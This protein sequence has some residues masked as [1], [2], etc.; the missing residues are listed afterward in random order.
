MRRSWMVLGT[1]LAFAACGGDSSTNPDTGGDGDNSGD[2]RVVK[3]DPSFQS[4]IQE[5]FDRRG[6]AASSCHGSAEAAGLRL[7]SGNSHA[8]LV[9]VPATSEAG[10][11]V[12]T[13]DAQNSYLV[14]KIEGRQ[15]AGGRMPVGGSP[16]DTIDVKNIRNWIDQGAKN[17]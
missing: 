8:E 6:C 11:R 1:A 7:T 14:I 5:I 10:T 2:N 9:G 4:D 12:I 15:T 16:L 3:L 13:G 17:N